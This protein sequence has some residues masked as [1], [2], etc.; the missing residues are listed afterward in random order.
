MQRLLIIEDF[1]AYQIVSST[2]T[3]SA[4]FI[5]DSNWKVKLLNYSSVR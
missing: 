4:D 3:F 2:T 5:D 1:G